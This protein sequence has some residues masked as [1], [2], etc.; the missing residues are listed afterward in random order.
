MPKGKRYFGRNLVFWEGL[1][2]F[3]PRSASQHKDAGLPSTPR[4]HTLPLHTNAL[5]VASHH[6]PPPCGP[7]PQASREAPP[8]TSFACWPRSPRCWV[9]PREP[10][11]PRTTCFAAAG[12]KTD[13]LNVVAAWGAARGAG[14]RGPGGGGAAADE[15]YGYRHVRAGV[16]G[17]PS[18]GGGLRPP[19]RGDERGAVAQVQGVTRLRRATGLG[20]D[21]RL[22]VGC[23]GMRNYRW[24]LA[25]TSAAA[26]AGARVPVG[27]MDVCRAAEGRH[28]EVLRWRGST[29]ARG[30]RAYMMHRAW[31]VVHSPLRGDTLMRCSGF[32]TSGARLPMEPDD[33]C[34]ALLSADTLSC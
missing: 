24:A 32:G 4:P 28:L 18:G 25:P 33:V 21:E 30:R 14:A 10:S 3:L 16:A 31:A 13:H 29:A 27:C 6:V 8:A 17:E 22:P 12:E 15:T 19:A 23:E 5:V 34:A 20:Q 1:I 11:F 2:L 9:E 26:G 7:P